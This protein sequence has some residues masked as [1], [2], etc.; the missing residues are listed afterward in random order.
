MAGHDQRWLPIASDFPAGLDS[1]TDPTKLPDGLSPECYN[2]NIDK[3]GRLASLSSAQGIG[4]ANTAKTFVIGAETYTWYYQRLWM[5]SSA[6]LHYLAPEIQDTVL[7]QDIG[8]L[9]F[10]ETT[11]SL[12]TFFPFANDA[13]FVGKA[14]GGYI[15]PNAASPNG[16][17]QHL[18]LQE[19]MQVPAAANAC[20]LGEVAYASN[21]N[22]LFAWDGQ[23]IVEVTKNA[24]DVLSTYFTSCTLRPDEARRRLVGS[25]GTTAKFVYDP[26]SKRLFPFTA[27]YSDFRFTTRTLVDKRY[28]PFTVFK[29]GFNFDNTT[30]ADAQ[31]VYQ[32]KTDKDWS[33][34]ITVEIRPDELGRIRKESMLPTPLQARTFAMRITSLPTNIEIK[35]IDVLAEN[36]SVEESY[37]E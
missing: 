20:P 3:P 22:G 27:T 15:I 19:A 30:S 1:D 14:V 10:D 25:N 34:D 6:A 8:K 33:G 32:T 21:T 5:I 26:Q 23:N 4:T 18:D 37:S 11:G 28:R 16:R 13:M 31:I 7:Y 29:V 17:F 2:M 36:I 9:G 35:Q 12:I 24:Q